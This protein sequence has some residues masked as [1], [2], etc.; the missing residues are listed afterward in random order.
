VIVDNNGNEAEVLLTVHGKLANTPA[1]TLSVQVSTQD[2]VTIS[3][4]GVVDETMMFGPALRLTSTLS[5]EAGS[6]ML[7]IRDRVTN[8]K[9]EPA[10]FQLLY[11]CNYGV[12]LLERGSKLL[13]P[14]KLVAPRDATA[15]GGVDGFDRFGRPQ[16]GF[17]EQVYFYELVG[18]RGSGETVVL[19][20]NAKGDAG[21]SLRFSLKSMPCFTLW[22]NTAAKEDGYV[23]GLE[24]ATNYPNARRF[25]RDQGRV[26]VLQGGESWETELRVAVHDSRKQVRAVEAEINGL[27]MAARA[28]VAT[29][30]LGKLS[31]V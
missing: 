20:R 22:K 1:R 4:T 16:P 3:V 21:S 10:E 13:A 17:V 15:V 27:Q 6:N 11:H 28:T 30:P 5:T 18:K 31:P 24:P 25:E 19:L 7:T 29:A 26:P 8:M 2:P 12:P 9:R 23:T 14:F